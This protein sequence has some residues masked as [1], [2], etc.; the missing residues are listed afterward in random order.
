METMTIEERQT[1]QALEVVEQETQRALS[2]Q[3][4]ISALMVASDADYESAGG[5]VL[6]AKD[7]IRRLEEKRRGITDHLNEALRRIND[8]FR[9]PREILEGVVRNLDGKLATYRTDQER[10]RHE[11]E[12]RLRRLAEEE[13]AKRLAVAE[14]KAEK[15]EAKGLTD[16]AEAVR[17]TAQASV[18]PPPVLAPAEPP[19]VQGLG[20]RKVWKFRIVKADLIPREYLVPDETKIGG[21]VR[22]LKDKTNIPGVEA[23]AEDV[24]IGRT[25]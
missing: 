22:A 17:D 18:I 1:S 8:L 24:S 21:V 15:L 23:Y 12:A 13:N 6:E 19:K 16:A 10:K 7:A 25:R 14:K 2:F 5:L 11:E 3:G 20:S 9:K 4:Q